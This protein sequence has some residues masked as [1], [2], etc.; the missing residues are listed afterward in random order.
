MTDD[1][2]GPGK[3]SLAGL[4]ESLRS[5]GDQRGWPVAWGRSNDDF[6]SARWRE[7]QSDSEGAEAGRAER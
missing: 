2:E 3:G 1:G 7:E 5:S 4:A 6:S